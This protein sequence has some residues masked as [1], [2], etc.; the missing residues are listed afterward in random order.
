MG[1][2][3]SGKRRLCRAVHVTMVSGAVLFGADTAGAVTIIVNSAVDA[4]PTVV[5]GNCTLREAIAA[6]EGDDPVDSCPTG[7]GADTIRFAGALAGS[8]ISLGTA[9]SLD[10]G[11]GPRTTTI[12]GDVDGDGSADISLKAS[13]IVSTF[14]IHGT[15][16]V[17]LAYLSIIGHQPPMIPD[18]SGDGGAIINSSVLHL[19]HV[20][21]RDGFADGNGGGIFNNYGVLTIKDSTI[22]GNSAAFGGGIFNQ[23]GNVTISRTILSN[24]T[25]T[26]SGGGIFNDSGSHSWLSRSTLSSNN[27]SGG[28][29]IT[30]HGEFTIN[31]STLLDNHATAAGGG[32]L[33][34]SETIIRN[35]T[36]VGNV[37]HAGGAASA[38][39][40][41]YLNVVHSTIVGNS[42]ERG[43]GFRLGDFGSIG[44]ASL[45]KSIVAHNN[46]GNCSRGMI[47]G[48]SGDGNLFYPS[49]DEC[50]GGIVG[51][52]QL[53][54]LADNTGP[55][56]TMMPSAWGMAV[57]MV[58]CADEVNV[59]QR[60][61]PRS[62]MI[63]SES[64]P[65]CDIGAVELNR[66][67]LDRIFGNDFD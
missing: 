5:N 1:V 61:M 2:V 42:A 59:D 20:T 57:D 66:I 8:T 48:I 29:G 55:T 24:N 62:Q 63:L 51:D 45:L 22:T 16:D 10:G 30:N 36:L 7:L 4:N 44:A 27:A 21:V 67:D 65:W 25:A 9:L 31:Q 49:M 17:T 3:S 56:R 19:D 18:G 34:T 26:T 52:P 13:G 43:G 50:Y 53:E 11:I 41:G 15:A 6:A 64:G 40:G 32:I 12:T 39:M 14:N 28:G 54:P 23:S 58:E 60:G 47:A 33:T 38:Q 46:G 35:S 37:A